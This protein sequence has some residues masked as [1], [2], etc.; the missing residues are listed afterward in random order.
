MKF[1]RR[2]LKTDP[3]IDLVSFFILRHKNWQGHLASTQELSL[4]AFPYEELFTQD[5]Q[6]FDLV[7]LQNFWFGSF[8]NFDDRPF[9][10]SLAKYVEDGGALIMVGG[11]QS[12]GAAGY[13]TSPL[14]R[15]LPTAVPRQDFDASNFTAV[16][17]AAGLR[18]PVTRLERGAENNGEHWQEMPQLSGLNPLGSLEEGGV[19]LLSAGEGGGPLLAVRQVGKGRTLAF[20]SDTSW[21]WALAGTGGPG[22]GRDHAEVWR[23]A[24]R[25]LVKD[26]E[27]RQIQVIT[28][29]ENYRLGDTVQAQVRVLHDDY[30]PR[31]GAHVTGSMEPLSGGEPS[32][33]DGMTDASG[34]VTAALGA[35]REGTWRIQVE[36]AGI[37]APFGRAEARISVAD[38]EGELEDPRARADLLA[39]IAQVTGGTAFRGPPDPRKANARPVDAL[40]ATD[41]RVEPLWS[42]PLLLLL[43]A[44]PLGGEWILRRRAGL[45]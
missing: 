4:I 9:M 33:I 12:F 7:I 21:R 10:E 25:W 16:P 45:R 36:V 19:E 37:P 11:D 41:R 1:L 6:G 18:H 29:R 39:S 15:V 23:S 38:R 14:A 24:V 43:L 5:L 40:L 34:Q 22:G 27:Q 2:L 20:A 35:D 8:A 17:T 42:H 26:A 13:G 44:L 30:S 28:D 32:L 3:N 31:E